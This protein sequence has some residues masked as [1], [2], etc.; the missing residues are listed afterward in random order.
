M[1]NPRQRSKARSS[2]AKN[3]KSK[4]S[5]K[6]AK[7]VV[8][9]GPE[10]VRAAWDVKKTLRQNYAAMGLLSSMNPRQKG[11]VEPI[12]VLRSMETTALAGEEPKLG[13]NGEIPRGYAKLVRD[14]A[15]NVIDVIFADEEGFAPAA[16]PAS[17][18][19]ATPWGR[20]LNGGDGAEEWTGIAQIEDSG[21]DQ[22][23]GIPMPESQ[24]KG[25][26]GIHIQ[27]HIKP[28]TTTI[29]RMSSA[30]YFSTFR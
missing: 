4:Q 19:T 12:K 1:A 28:P 6:N 2:V 30:S 15:G 11:G 3:T 14:E 18:S 27:N 16:D 25:G 26:D 23:Q 9:R 8:V 10:A 13:P 22:P 5:V 7:K 24:H 17:T 29:Q 21:L 20:P